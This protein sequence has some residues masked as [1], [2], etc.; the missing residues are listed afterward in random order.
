MQG[1]VLS[2]FIYRLSYFFLL[3]PL[4]SP[5]LTWSLEGKL[6][7]PKPHS[8][9]LVELEFKDH[10]VCLATPGREQ[11]ISFA[12]GEK[13]SWF[14]NMKLCCFAIWRTPLTSNPGSWGLGEGQWKAIGVGVLVKLW[15]VFTETHSCCDSGLFSPI[16]DL[17][18]GVA[19]R[20]L[21]VPI[22]NK[23][24]FRKERKNSM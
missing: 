9:T 24:C 4:S 13:G 19:R 12:E 8:Q 21:N 14:V 11:R 15:L 7:L 10:S 23:F 18:Q 6:T 5:S 22:W 16:H 1:T 2:A 17:S 3:A 20:Q